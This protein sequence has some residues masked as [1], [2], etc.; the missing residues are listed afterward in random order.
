MHYFSSRN[1]R[2]LWE[3]R[4]GRSIR[5]LLNNIFMFVLKKVNCDFSYNGITLESGSKVNMILVEDTNLSR[6]VF[7]TSVQNWPIRHLRL[8]EKLDVSAF[9]AC[10]TSDAQIEWQADVSCLN[11]NRRINAES[12]IIKMLFIITI[13]YN[14]VL[15]I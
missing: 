11:V 5:R 8:V 10:S 1:I 12:L 15:L 3:Q 7:P 2:H 9:F 4:N 6:I 13:L 14:M